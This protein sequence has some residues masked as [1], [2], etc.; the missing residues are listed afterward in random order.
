[1]LFK[2][3]GRYTNGHTA[4]NACGVIFEG[5]EPAEVSDPDAI[6]RLSQNP[7][8]AAVD[9]LDHDGDGEKGGSLP[10]VKATAKRARKPKE[11]A[12]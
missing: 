7:E 4:I 5:D 6:R 9:P 11:Q 1:M 8:F 2:F 10:G 3:V 12:E